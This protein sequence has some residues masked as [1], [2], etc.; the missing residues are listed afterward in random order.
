MISDQPY[1]KAESVQLP[2]KPIGGKY[3]SK[4]LLIKIDPSTR[5]IVF[6]SSETKKGDQQDK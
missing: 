6:V 1:Q 2:S 3:Q 4:P 5:K